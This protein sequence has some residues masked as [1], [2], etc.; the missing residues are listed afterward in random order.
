MAEHNRRPLATRGTAW[1]QALAAALARSS[2][3]PNGI[4]LASIVFAAAGAGLLLYWPTPAGLVLC[5]LCVQLRLLCNLLDGMV[6]VEGGKGTPVGVLYNEL[7][8]RI[9][10]ALLLVALGYAA[11]A[12]WLGWL[13]ALLAAFTAY[14]RV[15][16]GSLGLTQD[17]RGPQAK[18]QRMFVMTVA[19][20]AAAAE[21]ALRG[22]VY[23]LLLAAGII[24]LGSALTCI[25]R[26]HAIARRLR[27]RSAA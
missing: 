18:P 23:A 20:L 19:C 22:S 3:T 4:S 2:V 8:D 12:A 27:A 17:F 15:T 9:A 26:S 25:A 7:P 1:A 5:A 21:L 10:D 13:C 11:G 16:G 14:I 6:A 24:A